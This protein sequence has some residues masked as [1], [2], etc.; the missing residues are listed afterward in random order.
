[1]SLHQFWAGGPSEVHEV[2]TVKFHSTLINP[3]AGTKQRD[4]YPLVIWFC[5]LGPS[6]LDGI[7]VELA[8]LSRATSKPFVLV[9]PIRPL[10]FWWVLDDCR[11]PW[12]CMTG[13]LMISEVDKYCRW[14]ETL[15][16]VSG[17]DRTSVS[18]FLSLIHI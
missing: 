7:G 12:G 9:A 18:L 6:G 3:I 15:A 8:W 2:D 13:S 17:I 10:T 16:E 5:G 11:P 14:I 1:M 4:S